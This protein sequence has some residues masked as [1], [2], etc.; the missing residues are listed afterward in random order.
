VDAKA[1]ALWTSA[2]FGAAEFVIDYQPPKNARN[3]AAAPATLFVRGRNGEGV[4]VTLTAGEGG[5]FSRFVVTVQV[6]SIRVQRGTEPAQEIPLP[7]GTPARGALGF[8]A[9]AGGGLFMNLHAR[10]L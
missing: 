2:E 9:G 1:A 7:A 4:P 10:D 5:K 6:A 8:A 3:E